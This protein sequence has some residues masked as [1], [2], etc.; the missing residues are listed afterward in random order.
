MSIGEVTKGDYNP[1]TNGVLQCTVSQD[2]SFTEG[3]NYKAIK[4]YLR[5]D[6]YLYVIVDNK[7]VERSVSLVGK[8]WKFSIKE[9]IAE[10]LMP[11]DSQIYAKDVI[12][13]E[14]INLLQDE[15]SQGHKLLSRAD[16]IL[17]YALYNKSGLEGFLNEYIE[18]AKKYA[19]TYGV[20]AVIKKPHYYLKGLIG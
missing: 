7:G 20:Y 6:A 11:R 16:I 17:I 19:D 9:D 3:A 8:M 1:Q 18:Y 13:W 4:K 5:E 2:D 14:I 10:S 12:D 15:D